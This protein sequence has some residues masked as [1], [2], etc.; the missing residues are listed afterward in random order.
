MPILSEKFAPPP[1]T[2]INKYKHIRKHSENNKN[3]RYTYSALNVANGHIV[4]V[5]P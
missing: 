2:S 4:H 5:R 3:P 1:K